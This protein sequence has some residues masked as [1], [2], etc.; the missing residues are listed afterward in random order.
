MAFVCFELTA[1]NVLIEYWAPGLNPA[2]VISV[3]IV[4]L[5]AANGVSVKVYGE[6]GEYIHALTFLL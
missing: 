6:V 4:L 5:A 2:I 3:G 1:L